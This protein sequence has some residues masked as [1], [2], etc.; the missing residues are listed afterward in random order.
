MECNV[1][2]RENEWI[3][4]ALIKVE[5][6]IWFISTCQTLCLSKEI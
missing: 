5:I 2:I 6:P 4:Y 3:A 1:F